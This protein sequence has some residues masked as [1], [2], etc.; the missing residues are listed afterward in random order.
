MPDPV[1]RK[2]HPCPTHRRLHRL[3]RISERWDGPRIRRAERGGAKGSSVLG[4]WALRGTGCV[5]E[6]ASMLEHGRNETK[7]NKKGDGSDSV[8]RFQVGWGNFQKLGLTG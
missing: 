8:P 1:P 2:G 5:S 7:Q 3:P 6:L 4:D